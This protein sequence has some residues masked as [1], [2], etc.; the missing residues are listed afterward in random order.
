MMVKVLILCWTLLG[1]QALLIPLHYLQCNTSGVLQGTYAPSMTEQPMPGTRLATELY[2]FL[3]GNFVS[4]D[5]TDKI[6][7]GM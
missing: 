4:F 6:L 1:D 3:A 7:T 5:R 2:L